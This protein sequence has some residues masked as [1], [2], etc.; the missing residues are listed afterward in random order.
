M[1]KLADFINRAT[2]WFEAK[3]TDKREVWREDEWGPRPPPEAPIPGDEVARMLRDAVRSSGR[4]LDPMHS[5]H[6]L[7]EIIGYDSSIEARRELARELGW[8]G[9]SE[10][11][12]SAKLN[13][14]L[15]DELMK[16]L[17]ERKIVIG[18]L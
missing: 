8:G 17:A 12:G 11:A 15:H 3:W 18:G 16:R 9:E 14:W 13:V 10:G 6:D 1:S 7:C 5:V 2:A 4:P